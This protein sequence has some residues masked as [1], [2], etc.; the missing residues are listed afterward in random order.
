M[1]KKYK[2]N[3]VQL[4]DLECIDGKYNVSKLTVIDWPWVDK[5]AALE[6]I[7]IANAE[8][9]AFLEVVYEMID[10]PNKDETY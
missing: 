4:S 5:A 9:D 6:I 7:D 1:P 8:Y 3:R 2:R 10:K